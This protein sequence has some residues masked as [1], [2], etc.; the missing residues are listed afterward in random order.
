MTLDTKARATAQKLLVKFGK[1]CTLKSTVPGTYN[2]ATGSVTPVVTVYAIK[3]YLD[4]PNKAELAGGQVVA[5]DEVAIFAAQG[6]AVE[7]AL[8]D[9]VTIDGAD[10]L[11]KMVGRVWSGELVALWRVGLVS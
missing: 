9:S 7:P 11:V 6:L 8:N 2:P 1:D 10:R 3:A 4:Q 5:T